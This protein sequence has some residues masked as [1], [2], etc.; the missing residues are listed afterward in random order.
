[1]RNERVPSSVPERKVP[2]GSRSTPARER[3]GEKSA[4][5]TAE[6]FAPQER[7]VL[8]ISILSE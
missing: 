4:R 3:E 7:T 1:M 6:V 2:G 5:G 8:T